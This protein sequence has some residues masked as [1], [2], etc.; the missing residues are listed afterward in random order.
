LAKSKD[1]DAERPGRLLRTRRKRPR[2][3]RAADERDELVPM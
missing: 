3:R 1:P 2:H